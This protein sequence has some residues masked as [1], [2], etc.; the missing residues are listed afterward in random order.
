MDGRRGLDVG[1]DMADML[2]TGT[3]DIPFGSFDVAPS[4]V[5][6]SCSEDSDMAQYSRTRRKKGSY[7]S[8]R[9]LRN[10]GFEVFSQ[11]LTSGVVQSTHALTEVVRI[12]KSTLYPLWSK[13]RDR[14]VF[15]S[16]EE[17]EGVEN[18]EIGEEENLYHDYELERV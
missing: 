1:K 17:T 7:K 4:E 6:T 11:C 3:S 5:N 8:E 2:K 13:E 18:V 14:N 9:A 12:T 15:P 16:V 10:A